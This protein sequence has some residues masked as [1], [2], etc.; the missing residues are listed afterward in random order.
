LFSQVRRNLVEAL[1]DLEHRLAYGTSERL[2]LGA[3]VAAF[4]RA[5]EDV[6]AAAAAAA[7]TR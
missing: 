6:V 7:P 3:L 5:R 4:V 1:A 2:Q